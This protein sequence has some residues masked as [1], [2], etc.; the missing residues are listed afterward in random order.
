MPAFTAKIESGAV[1]FLKLHIRGGDRRV[2]VNARR[3]DD[4]D[5]NEYDGNRERVDR[6]SANAPEQRTGH[7]KPP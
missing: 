7:R 3:N 4:R 5:A 1:E 2:A 6:A